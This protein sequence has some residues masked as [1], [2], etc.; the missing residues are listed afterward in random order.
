MH[1]L[2]PASWADHSCHSPWY[3]LY[4][5]PLYSTAFLITVTHMGE[6]ERTMGVWK[7]LINQER[8]KKLEE[9][10]LLLS[11]KW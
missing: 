11:L 1:T 7:K 10:M 5:Y 6:V 9:K 3:F 2:L 4:Y 8:W